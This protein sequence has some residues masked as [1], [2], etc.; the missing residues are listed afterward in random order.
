LVVTATSPEIKKRSRSVIYVKY[1]PQGEKNV[2]IGPVDPEIIDIKGFILSGLTQAKHTA[3]LASM[4]S[5]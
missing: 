4:P 2:K 5:G 1:L 3:L